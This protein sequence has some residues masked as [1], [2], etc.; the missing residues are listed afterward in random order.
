MFI[1]TR[2]I[3][4]NST[5]IDI[6]N[7]AIGVH[8]ALPVFKCF[9]MASRLTF[10]LKPEL[11]SSRMNVAVW[12]FPVD[13]LAYIHPENGG[14]AIILNFRN[15][16]RNIRRDVPEKGSTFH[17]QCCEDIRSKI[18]HNYLRII[19]YKIKIE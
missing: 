14:Y 17:G 15:I 5:G 10:A 19:L 13:C 12:L 16:C 8:M 2:S 3:S 7:N 18:I 4:Q 11:S 6:K 9:L 1:R